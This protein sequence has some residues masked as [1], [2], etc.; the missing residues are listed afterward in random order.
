MFNITNQY[1]NA[2]QSL[3]EANISPIRIATRKNINKKNTQKITVVGE[4]VEKL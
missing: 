1:E 4:L 2:N 3:N